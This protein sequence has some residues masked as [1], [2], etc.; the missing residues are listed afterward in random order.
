MANTSSAKKA[1][2]QNIKN[3]LANKSKISEV[4]TFAKKVETEI[5]SSNKENAIAALKQFEKIGMKAVSK[6]LFHINTIARKISRLYASIK[7]IKVS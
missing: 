6:K 2:R 1:L 3:R 4:R 7:N 5:A